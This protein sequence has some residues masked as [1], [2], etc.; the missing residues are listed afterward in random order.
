MSENKSSSNDIE[1][2]QF[3][4]LGKLGDVIFTFDFEIEHV[5]NKPK[6]SFIVELN[7]DLQAEKREDNL[8]V[9]KFNDG[10]KSDFVYIAPDK[11]YV[12]GSI[13]IIY[14][15]TPIGEFWDKKC[16]FNFDLEYGEIEG[17]PHTL[18]GV[19]P[20]IDPDHPEES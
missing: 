8:P 18:L 5:P 19:Y 9:Y 10:D 4:L 13:E 16:N 2:R 7:P 12:K 1:K 20:L 3:N 17:S 6:V 11:F 15:G 14:F